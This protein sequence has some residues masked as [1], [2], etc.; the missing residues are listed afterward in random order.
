MEAKKYDPIIPG[1]TGHIPSDYY[2]K[3]IPQIEAI[4]GGHIPGYS[5]YVNKIKPE[6]YFGKSFGKITT[7]INL[8]QAPLEEKFL[9]TNQMVYID[10]NKIKSKKASEIVGVNYKSK[11]Y[12]KPS[13][14][15]LQ[16][17]SSTVKKLED[18]DCH[19]S[20]RKD[21]ENTAPL[22][23]NVEYIHKALPGFTGHNRKVY[24]NNIYSLSF[25][26]AQEEAQVKLKENK[27]QILKNIE[28]EC[29]KIPPLFV[30]K[31]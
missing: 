25:K 20:D 23:D 21:I 6:N 26:R 29:S 11:E 8:S 24:A 10:Q 28:E 14:E 15:E 3:Q 16:Q 4:Q 5:G 18:S 2:D 19:N 1:Y 7:E 31:R 12:I 27:E 13:E 22:Y 9:S 30:S 17:L